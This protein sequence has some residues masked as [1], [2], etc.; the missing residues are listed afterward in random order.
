MNSK[1]QTNPLGSALGCGYLQLFS[2]SDRRKRCRIAE[3][4]LS[5]CQRQGA[6]SGSLWITLKPLLSSA[7][8]FT[9]T[10][11]SHPGHAHDAERAPRQMGRGCLTVKTTTPINAG[12]FSPPPLP[13]TLSHSLIGYLLT[14]VPSA[15]N[16]YISNKPFTVTEAFL[17]HTTLRWVSVLIYFYSYITSIIKGMRVP[18]IFQWQDN[19]VRKHKRFMSFHRKLWLK[20]KKHERIRREG[21]V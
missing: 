15:N 1:C 14:F 9:L 4:N 7:Q 17:S 5:W 6:V 11:N 19:N 12:H 16:P 18:F 21:R 8:H 3:S 13:Q 10:I 20:E 2:A